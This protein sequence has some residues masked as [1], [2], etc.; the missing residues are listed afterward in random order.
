MSK[1]KLLLYCTKAK[2]RL[3]KY[4]SIDYE[5]SAYKYD[6]GYSL[7]GKIVAECD[8]EKVEEIELLT[9][10][11]DSILNGEN[12]EIDLDYFLKHSCL[13][14]GQLED[15]L[16]T[17][18]GTDYTLTKVGYA[19]HL[20]NVKIFDKPI[21]LKD[22][23]TRECNWNKCSKCEYG[24]DGNIKCCTIDIPL[25][26]A[27]QNMMWVWHKGERKV[28]ISIRSQHLC[29]ILNRRKTIEVRKKILK[30]M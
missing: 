6:E 26:K 20:S 15:Y 10:L 2:P 1:V 17:I 13:K 27:H 19:L 4:S 3:W 28:L 22:T 16:K 12:G 21:E 30:G 18:D 5:G 7:N 24:K 14:Y 8:C 29:N 23:Y 25:S 9:C 11:G